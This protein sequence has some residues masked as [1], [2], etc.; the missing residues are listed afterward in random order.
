[1]ARTSAVNVP[2]LERVSR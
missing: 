2:F 1:M